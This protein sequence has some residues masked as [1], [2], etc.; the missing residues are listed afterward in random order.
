MTA[1]ATPSFARFGQHSRD[2]GRSDRRTLVMYA[3]FNGI[4][5]RQCWR[6]LGERSKRWLSPTSP[7]R[8]VF[9]VWITPLRDPGDP[10]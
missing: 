10:L 4:V 8:D 1:H 5:A 9:A 7:Q 2:I 6:H 3:E